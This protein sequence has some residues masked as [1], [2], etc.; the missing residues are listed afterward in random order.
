MADLWRRLA[1]TDAYGDCVLL[2]D[3]VAAL[4]DSPFAAAYAAAV[5]RA[6]TA[7]LLT[8][9]GAA[10]L[11]EFGSG[12]GRYDLTRQTEH[13]RHYRM[14][15]EELTSA[16]RHRASVQGKLYRTTGLAGG[17]ALALLLL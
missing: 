16:L 14:Q 17:V 4:P 9:V 6:R 7:G 3:T 8:P 13:I 5:E 11:A 10:L 1:E 2:R 15:A 12:C